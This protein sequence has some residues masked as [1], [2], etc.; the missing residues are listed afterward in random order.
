MP[1]APS[2]ISGMASIVLV[3]AIARALS[4]DI[5]LGVLAAGLFAID[6]L[7]LVHSR[8]GTLD[9]QLTLWPAPRRLSRTAPST[10]ARRRGVRAGRA[11]QGG[12]AVYGMLALLA[13]AD[14]GAS[15]R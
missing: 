14:L 11:H 2:L 3:Y 15:A 9:M 5:W 13:L 10:A 8:I 6:N 12:W 4:A 7:T 1:Q